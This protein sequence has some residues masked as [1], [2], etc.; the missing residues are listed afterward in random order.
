MQ[1]INHCPVG[2]HNQKLFILWVMLSTLETTVARIALQENCSSEFIHIGITGEGR[3][4]KLAS[5]GV[6]TGCDGNKPQ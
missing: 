2:R 5:L 4:I 1:G 3:G 6:V